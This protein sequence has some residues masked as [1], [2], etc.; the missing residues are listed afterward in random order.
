MQ[1]YS[2]INNHHKQLSSGNAYVTAS[3]LQNRKGGFPNC[4]PSPSLYL[5]VENTSGPATSWIVTTCYGN[6]LYRLSIRLVRP[7]ILYS[8]LDAWCSIHFDQAISLFDFAR[9]LDL[10]QQT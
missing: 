1:V 5:R 7:L 6:A 9:T 3:D 8:L 10:E 2:G 4:L